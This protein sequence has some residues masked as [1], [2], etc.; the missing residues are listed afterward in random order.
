MHLHILMDYT[1][2]ERCKRVTE[3]P[4][5]QQTL[6][7]KLCASVFSVP[8]SAV[9]WASCSVLCSQRYI[10]ADLNEPCAFGAACVVNFVNMFLHLYVFWEIC[11]IFALFLK[12]QRV[13]HNVSGLDRSSA[14][15]PVGHRMMIQVNKVN[16]LHNQLL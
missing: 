11:V 4:E 13:S 7:S 5:R 9:F 10:Y 14:F 8:V 16:I 1:V 12:V 2:A 15:A 3:T 6:R